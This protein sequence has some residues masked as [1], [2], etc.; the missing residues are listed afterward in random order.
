MGAYLA[1]LKQIE[2]PL[3]NHLNDPSKSG[4][5]FAAALMDFHGRI[6]YDA[7]RELGKDTLM[8]VLRA[9]PPIA[10]LAAQIPE[11]FEQFVDDFLNADEILAEQEELEGEPEPEPGPEVDSGRRPPRPVVRTVAGPSVRPAAPTGAAAGATDGAPARVPVAGPPG[12]TAGVVDAE[13]VGVTPEAVTPEVANPKRKLK[14]K[15]V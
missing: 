7:T 9:Y 8:S 6:A 12:A 1:M 11:R 10:Q 3:I 15:P 13:V 4:A 14:A 5:D 2:R